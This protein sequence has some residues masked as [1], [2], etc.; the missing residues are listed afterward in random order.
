MN[1]YLV[2]QNPRYQIAERAKK[3]KYFLSKEFN[4]HTHSQS[5]KKLL[6]QLRDAI[7]V[8]G[9][10]I[11]TEIAYVEWVR[12]YILFHNKNHPQDMGEPEIETFLTYLAVDQDVAAST[13]N[14]ALCALLFLYKN[15]LRKPLDHN[16]IDAVR[17]KRP[18]RAPTVLTKNETQNLLIHITGTLGIMAR[19]MYGSGM[20]ILECVRLRVKDIDFGHSQITI[21]NGKGFKDRIT[22]LPKNLTDP[23][24]NHLVRINN[25][26]QNDLKKGLGSVYLPNA[27]D[28]KLGCSRDWRWQYIFPANR[29]ST[30]PR[31]G[32][33]RRHHASTSALQRAIKQAANFA[34]IEKRVTSHT[35]RHSFATHLLEDGYDIR[36]VQELLGH[37]DVKTTMIYTHVL[38]RGPMAV[39]SPLD[40]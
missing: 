40:D 2:I 13:Q 18:E 5:P 33:E 30:D 3:P 34:H 12:R 37:K 35:L 32:I 38:N 26:H 10:S 22:I 8:K 21:R 25:Q 11:R 17:A 16:I 19:L 7:R 6:D 9:Y 1:T 4:R 20:R 39:K 24:Q 29:I 15:V 27:L 31:T 14:Q 23:L 36:T 28:R